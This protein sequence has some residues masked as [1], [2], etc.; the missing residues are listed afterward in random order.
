MHKQS[1][2]RRTCV[3]H[4]VSAQPSPLGALKRPQSKK[5]SQETG[6]RDCSPTPVPITTCERPFLPTY[7][8]QY[9]H[10]HV[11]LVEIEPLWSSNAWLK[12][13]FELVAGTVREL[14]RH[15]LI[16]KPVFSYEAYRGFAEDFAHIRVFWT[17]VT[18][19]AQQ[20]LKT[21]VGHSV[22]TSA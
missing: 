8:D 2:I 16:D 10:R 17:Y 9:L 21:V 13:T 4:Y 1:G 19:Y 6:S 5:D 3:Q 12:T 11:V 14:V 20:T 22:L 15:F 18:L 7:L